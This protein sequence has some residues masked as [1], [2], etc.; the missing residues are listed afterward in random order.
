[1]TIITKETNQPTKQPTNET[2]KQTSIKRESKQ[3]DKQTNKQ[4]NKQTYTDGQRQYIDWRTRAIN[5][6]W[7]WDLYFTTDASFTHT[8]LGLPTQVGH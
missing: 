2:N 5:G 1:M 3:T 8:N 4:T 7:D 6:E